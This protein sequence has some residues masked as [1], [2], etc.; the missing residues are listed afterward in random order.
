[1]KYMPEEIEGIEYR[2]EKMQE[3]KD[4]LYSRLENDE[5]Q[6]S[7]LEYLSDF[8]QL[9]IKVL[10]EAGV[11]YIENR[12]EIHYLTGYDEDTQYYLGF[13]NKNVSYEGRFVFPILNGLGE[14]NAWNGYDSDSKSKYLVGLL[15]VGDKKNLLYGINDIDRAFE[16]DTIIVNEGLFERLRLKEM[17]LNVGVSLLGKKM[18]KWQK[19]YIN[20]FKNKILIPDGD[21]EGQDMITQW[22][23]GLTGNICVVKLKEEKRKY[24]V[25]DEWVE[26]RVKDLDD[27]LRANPE[28]QEEFR[29]MYK[30]IKERLKTEMYME[31]NF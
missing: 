13:L 4:Y 29:D 20:R 17:D 16:E 2:Y 30:L 26:K 3:N 9:D 25:M 27:K 23:E 5:A 7:L 31:I 22:K 18:S 15:G 21:E 28:K 1:M 8:R 24:W 14:L 19:K 6:L 10:K 11:F 12:N